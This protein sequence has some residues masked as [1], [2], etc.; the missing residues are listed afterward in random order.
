MKGFL[1]MVDF[2]PDLAIS[3]G[4]MFFGHYKRKSPRRSE[5]RFFGR[6]YFGKV[7]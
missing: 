6:V 2:G 7:R 4:I 1:D 3:M 5:R